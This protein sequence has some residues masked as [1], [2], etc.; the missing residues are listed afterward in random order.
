M[1]TI[2]DSIQEKIYKTCKKNFHLIFIFI[3]CQIIPNIICGADNQSTRIDSN[4]SIIVAWQE[5][6]ISGTEIK[7]KAK[8]F[9]SFFFEPVVTLSTTETGSLP[10]LAVSD[11]GL[12]M[13]AV[14]V[15]T[16]SIGGITHLYGAMRP[17]LTANWTSGNLV[18]DGIEDISGSYQLVI[19]SHGQIIATWISFINGN[20]DLR[21]STAIIN[22]SNSWDLPTTLNL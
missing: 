18:S 21:S 17:T 19:N 15:W 7:T 12:D 14:A 8:H 6:T 4:G 10:I 9:N 13:Y 11:N 2:L 3:I 22:N 1:N 5:N 16:E 20:F